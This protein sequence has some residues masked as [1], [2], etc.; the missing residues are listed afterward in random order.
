MT[1]QRYQLKATKARLYELVKRHFEVPVACQQTN[2]VKRSRNRDY[3]LKFFYEGKIYSFFLAECSG[4]VVL[5]RMV[6]TL[7][8]AHDR[9]WDAVDIQLTELLEQGLAEPISETIAQVKATQK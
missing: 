9:T 6:D 2:F 7:R 3:A 8:V 4:K 5:S 1:G